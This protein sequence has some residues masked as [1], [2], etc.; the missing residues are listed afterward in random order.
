L[1]PI[2][3]TELTTFVGLMPM[4]FERAMFARFM[5]PLAIS[6]AFGV[7]FASVITLILVPCAYLVLEDLQLLATGTRRRRAAE[8]IAAAQAEQ[9]VGPTLN[10]GDPTQIGDLRAR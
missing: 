6:L 2:F 10:A 9:A 5:I 7:V 3:L 1:R 8:R 4:L